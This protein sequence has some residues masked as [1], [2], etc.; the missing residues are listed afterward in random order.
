MPR[1]R[2]WFTK[3]RGNGRGWGSVGPI[4]INSYT[5]TICWF[6]QTQETRAKFRIFRL[7]KINGKK[8]TI[9]N[10]TVI[11]NTRDK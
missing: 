3:T 5:Y 1:F 4:D 9:D 2:F 8:I 10:V 7:D 6:L 11:D